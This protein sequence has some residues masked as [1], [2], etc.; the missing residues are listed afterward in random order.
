MAIGCHVISALFRC[1]SGH[2][3][4]PCHYQADPSPRPGPGR[5]TLGKAYPTAAP[6]SHFLATGLPLKHEKGS[7]KARGRSEECL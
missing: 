3:S 6:Y 7:R 4:L 1:S 5:R 2:I